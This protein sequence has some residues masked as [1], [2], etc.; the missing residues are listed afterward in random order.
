M[1]HGIAMA[2]E[3]GKPLIAT[4]ELQRDDIGLSVIVCAPGLRIYAHS[5]DLCT[6]YYAY[7]KFKLSK[8]VSISLAH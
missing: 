1:I 5:K 6:V 3:T 7:H 4:L 8:P 2:F